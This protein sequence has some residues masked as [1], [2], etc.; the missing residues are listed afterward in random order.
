VNGNVTKGFP[1]CD[2]RRREI[3][4]EKCEVQCDLEMFKLTKKQETSAG[5]RE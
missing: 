1:I 2:V 5:Y 3:F 4:L